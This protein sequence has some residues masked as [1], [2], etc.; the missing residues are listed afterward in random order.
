[1]ICQD[2]DAD[3]DA[4]Y[5]KLADCRV[6]HTVEVDSGTLVDLDSAGRLAGIEVIRPDRAWPLED[7]L[8]RFGV[9][10]TEAAELRESFPARPA[11]EKRRRSTSTAAKVGKTAAMVGTI[12]AV[13]RWRTRVGVR[14]R[15]SNGQ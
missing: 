3:A 9:S 15:A 11:S 14:S 8:H 13:I 12:A 4:L 1:M 7:I 5:L 10:P 6:A 2:Y